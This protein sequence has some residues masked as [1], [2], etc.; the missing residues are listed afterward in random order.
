MQLLHGRHVVRR[1]A[2]SLA[3][4]RLLRAATTTHTIRQPHSS[5]DPPRRLYGS[6][7]LPALDRKWQKRWEDDKN[8]AAAAASAL[9][10][11]DSDRPSKFVLPMFPYP[12][13][14]LHLGHLRVYT[15]ADVVARYRRLKGDDVVLP[16]GWDAFGL[17]AENAAMERGIAP[18]DWTK[19]NI[20]KMKEQL[21]MMNGSWDWSRVS[22]THCS[23]MSNPHPRVMLTEFVT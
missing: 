13:G 8:E 10:G 3:S 21:A 22:R 19:T 12:S 23:T 1:A 18:G 11:A 14:T 9:G 20:G 7:D 17:P 2:C 15:I 5:F 6:L 16:M 4:A